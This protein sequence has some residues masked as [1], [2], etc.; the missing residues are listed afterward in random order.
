MN[1]K[2]S[3]VEKFLQFDKTSYF[4]LLENIVNKAIIIKKNEEKIKRCKN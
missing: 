4:L 1:K 3:F 2:R